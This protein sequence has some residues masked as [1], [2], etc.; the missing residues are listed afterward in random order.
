MEVCKLKVE[1]GKGLKSYLMAKL[2]ANDYSSA[3]TKVKVIV[4]VII[5]INQS[6]DLWK[7]NT[8]IS[9]HADC[10]PK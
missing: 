3:W 9:K 5:I 10:N 8:L 4:M 1:I 7:S 6:S 2:S